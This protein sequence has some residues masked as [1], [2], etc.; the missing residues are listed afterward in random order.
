MEERVQLDTDPAD[1]ASVV[2][3]QRS[4]RVHPDGRVLLYRLS[5][6]QSDAATPPRLT[7]IT[8]MAG[9]LRRM[10]WNIP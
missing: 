7:V 10:E 8:D 4:D 3:Q 9:E 5:P 2:R 1:P 6:D